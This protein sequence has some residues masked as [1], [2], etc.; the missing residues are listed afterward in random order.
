MNIA[1]KSCAVMLC[2]V[3][4]ASCAND[5]GVP[6]IPAPTY[7]WVVEKRGW[8]GTGRCPGE[9]MLLKMD[10]ASS[11]TREEFDNLKTLLEEEDGC[12]VLEWTPETF[13]KYLT[14]DGTRLSGA[15]ASTISVGPGITRVPIGVGYWQ[16]P[17]AATKTGFSYYWNGTSWVEDPRS[18]A[19][20]S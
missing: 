4:L 7:D 11:L 1:P 13:K 5:R 16:G 10:P 15:F 20:S 8:L 2:C 6:R 12:Q 19:V 14:P 17:L 9:V 18:I 3:G